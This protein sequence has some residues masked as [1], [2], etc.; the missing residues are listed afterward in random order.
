MIA[1]KRRTESAEDKEARI[2][3]IRNQ[4]VGMYNDVPSPGEPNVENEMVWRHQVLGVD[5]SD[6]M[7]KSVLDVG[8]GA[9]D[10]SL[11]YA[12][13]GAREV[14]G[15]DLSK[16]SLEWARE[17]VASRGL[18]NVNH[19]QQNALALEFPSDHF[20]LSYSMGVLHH[21]GDT[22][23]GVKEMVRVTKPGGKII[24]SLY[25]LYARFGL[26]NKQMLCRLLGGED[27]HARAR[28]GRRLFPFTMRSLTKRYYGQHREAIS[29]DLFGYPHETLHTAHEVLG[30]FDELG[31]EY[32]GSFA[33]LR[34]KDYLY[35]FAQPEYRNFRKTFGGFPFMRLTGDMIA[36][37]SSMIG[38][39]SGPPFPKPGRMEALLT[40]L[41]WVPF[42]TR[43]Q[44]FTLAGRK[45]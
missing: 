45:K 20:D 17:K 34:F 26:R 43:F 5:P 16:T 22:F 23:G 6:F 2:E 38:S 36:K 29:Y 24:V 9:G 37:L 27:V 13:N 28:W 8:C 25:N 32:T 7:D 15:I 35:T 11:W 30:W 41:A 1:L 18:T 31:V 4:V 21:T 39:K 12:S 3:A 44:C 10:Y 14:T 42:S 33:P 19:L 40:Q